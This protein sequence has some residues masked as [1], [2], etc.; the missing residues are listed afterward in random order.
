VGLAA[1][2]GAV[3]IGQALAESV[4]RLSGSLTMET[5][6]TTSAALARFFTSLPVG[7]AGDALGNVILSCVA[8]TRRVAWLGVSRE[9]HLDLCLRLWHMLRLTGGQIMG[10]KATAHLAAALALALGGC[11]TAV[12]CGGVMD[13]EAPRCVYG[14]V[15]LDR[16][17][18]T[19]FFAT[20]FQGP[21][22][23][24]ATACNRILAGSFAFGCGVSVLAVDLPLSVVA[25]T[26]TLPL[27]VPTMIHRWNEA[28]FCPDLGNAADAAGEIGLPPAE[29]IEPVPNAKKKAPG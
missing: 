12:N 28:I 7:E 14:G 26:L 1:A 6:T 11:G 20:A 9:T 24:S 16:R 8:A 23:E 5:A 27:T 29:A 25:D 2:L 21:Y 18:S 4:V 22:P 3:L 10:R 13:P 15:S 19:H 17:W